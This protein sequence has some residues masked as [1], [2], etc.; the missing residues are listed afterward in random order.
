MNEEINDQNVI[1]LIV[2]H[3]KFEYLQNLI[4]LILEKKE[5]YNNLLSIFLNM[6]DENIKN[7][8]DKMKI[9]N[10]N[11]DK[12]II[13]T[14]ETPIYLSII[15]K[16]YECFSLL[17]DLYPIE[18][19]QYLFFYIKE[20]SP[21]F[22]TNYFKYFSNE[23]NK[24]KIKNLNTNLFIISECLSLIMNLPDNQKIK[25]EI[26]YEKL[27]GIIFTNVDSF[28]NESK[29][30]TLILKID[31][32][33]ISF[34]IIYLLINIFKIYPDISIFDLFLNDYSKLK[35]SYN[36]DNL[37]YILYLINKEN[38]KILAVEKYLDKNFGEKYIFESIYKIKQ[39]EEYKILIQN[40]INIIKIQK[41]YCYLLKK[42]Q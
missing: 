26:P 29:E 23:T 1:Q 17:L 38:Y 8:I 15:L 36:E 3:N 11:N 30:I 27:F 7:K 16:K 4:P 22:L 18:F 10:F 13:K 5:K 33:K 34:P 37:L 31:N 2:T 24:L 20:F 40:K 39:L 12:Y 14:S 21:L 25:Y 35:Y 32:I 9:K 6:N 42:I 19:I 41:K 28:S